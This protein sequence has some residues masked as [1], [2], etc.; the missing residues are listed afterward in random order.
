MENIIRSLEQVSG[1]LNHAK[2][3]KDRD[4]DDYKAFKALHAAVSQLFEVALM[5]QREI[6]KLQKVKA[7]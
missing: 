1:L 4:R 2:V 7:K 5:Q 3:M 6:E